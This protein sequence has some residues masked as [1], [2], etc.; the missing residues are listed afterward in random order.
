VALCVLAGY[1][2]FQAVLRQQALDIAL[3]H[4]REN[5]LTRSEIQALPQPLSPFN[6]KLLVIE[7]DIYRVAQVNLL[8]TGFDA[9]PPPAD[10]GF[11]SVLS[12]SYHSSDGLVWARY[13]RLGGNPSEASVVRAAWE[14]EALHEF[15][16]FAVYPAL[17]AVETGAVNECVSFVDLRFVLAGMAP[18]FRFAA[19]RVPPNGPWRLERLS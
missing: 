13:E 12:A 15:R 14:D 10:A 1:V 9:V 7:D 4:A 17:Y 6:W 11:L 8:P 18:P 19:C 16:R 5:G 2:C 3:T